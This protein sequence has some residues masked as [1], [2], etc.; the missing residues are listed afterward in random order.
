MDAATA[1]SVINDEYAARILLWAA[2]EPRTASEMSESLRIPVSACY[3]RIRL[4][5][6]VGLLKKV[7]VR[8]SASGKQIAVYQSILRKAL[9]VLDRGAVRIKF[10]LTD[11]SIEDMVLV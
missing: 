11:G 3:N 4:L 7:E 8:I 10:E 1:S 6:N 2:D 5:E 9:V